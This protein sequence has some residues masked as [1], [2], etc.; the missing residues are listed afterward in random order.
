MRF[1]LQTNRSRN[2][3]GVRSSDWYQT[4][5]LG[6]Y[7]LFVKVFF[8]FRKFSVSKV[9]KDNLTL[10][11]ILDHLQTSS[12][13]IR[14]ARAIPPINYQKYRNIE[15]ANFCP[16]LCSEVASVPKLTKYQVHTL[17]FRIDWSGRLQNPGIDTLTVETCLAQP[18]ADKAHCNPSI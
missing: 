2:L 14:L 9:W 3:L 12:P 17:D 10:D 13:R 8:V 5:A 18:C 7:F 1:Q 15:C 16:S 6:L 4:K 11:Q